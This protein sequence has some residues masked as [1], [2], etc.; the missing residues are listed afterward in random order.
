M[1]IWY[2]FRKLENYEDNNKI[3]QIS[4]NTVLKLSLLKKKKKEAVCT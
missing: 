1:N 4:Q 3:S 2:K